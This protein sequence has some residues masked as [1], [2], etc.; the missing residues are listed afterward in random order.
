MD[1]FARGDFNFAISA[2][3]V[4]PAD[5][6]AEILYRDK[7]VFFAAA[8]SPL[9]G[10]AHLSFAELTG[11]PLVGRFVDNF[12]GPMFAGLEKRGIRWPKQVDLRSS[13]AVKRFVEAG[14]GIGALFESSVHDELQAGTL[15]QL[16]LEGELFAETFWLVWRKDLQINLVAQR[17]RTF[18]QTRL[19]GL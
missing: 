4:F 10:R 17:F 7:L 13:E 12:W 2:Q 15:V 8:S 5:F 9:A 16:P 6:D 14:I 11:E 19:G 3:R 18:L 1:T